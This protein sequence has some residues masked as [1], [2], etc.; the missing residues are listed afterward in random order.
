MEKEF[1]IEKIIGNP[2][3]YYGEGNSICFIYDEP[4]LY[5]HNTD[6]NLYRNGKVFISAEK[7]NA[8]MMRDPIGLA[9]RG[10]TTHHHIKEWLKSK[11]ANID[12]SSDVDVPIRGRVSKNRKN[13]GIWGYDYI[14]S[15]GLAGTAWKKRAEKA[16]D[17]I[18]KYIK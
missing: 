5:W 4:W 11:G 3:K 6:G 13:I 12:I 9:S 7:I 2:D 17:L 18:Y 14:K 1:L 10:G 8:K 15:R 16:I